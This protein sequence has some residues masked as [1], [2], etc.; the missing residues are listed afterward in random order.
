MPFA[1]VS[2]RGPEFR[3]PS[4]KKQFNVSLCH[5]WKI[6]PKHSDLRRGWRVRTL[7]IIF[8]LMALFPTLLDQAQAASDAVWDQHPWYDAGIVCLLLVQGLSIIALVFQRRVR[9][10][11]EAELREANESLEK[12]VADRTAAL[13]ES[14]RRLRMALDAAYMISFE[15]DIERNTV[16]RNMSISPALPA[17][18]ERT[19]DTL[20]AVC[21]VV[22]PEDQ[23]HFI[24]RVKAAVDGEDAHYESEFRIVYPDGSVRWLHEHGLVERDT[25]GKA[26]R[27]IGLSQDI[28]ERKNMEIALRESRA[29][30]ESAL[31]SMTDAVFI[32]DINGCFIEINDAF[33]AY[34]RFKDK[35]ACSKSFSDNVKIL[36]ALTEDGQPVPFDQWAVP[37]ALRGERVSGAEYIMRRKDTGE[38]WVGSYSFGP[39]QEKDGRIAGAVIVARDVTEK[40]KAEQALKESEA[41]YRDL[42]ENANSAIIGWRC[43]GSIEYFNEFA[44]KLFGYTVDEVVGR[45]A[46]IL[47]PGKET[48]GSDLTGLVWDIVEY[49]DQYVNHINENIRR[50]GERI[51]MSWTNRPVFDEKGKVQGIL[52]IGNDITQQKMAESA[53][54]WLSQFP[55]E[56]PSP[57]LRISEKGD[58]LYRNKA[59]WKWLESIE[60]TPDAP[61][62]ASICAAVDEANEKNRP[63][64][65]EITGTSG[66][67]YGCVAVRPYGESYINLYC[68]DLTERKKVQAALE[69]SE[70]RLKASLTEKEVLLKEIHHR[71]KNNMQV[72]SSLV[73]LQADESGDPAVQSVL[74]DVKHRVRSMAM[75]HEK[76]Y[77]SADLARVEFSDYAR[78][79]L[80]YIQSSQMAPDFAIHLNID[81]EPLFLPIN[82]AVP[83]GLI[84]NE[85]FSN[86]LKHAFIGRKN[87]E[88]AVS[89]SKKD[90]GAV[91][92]YVKDNGIGLPRTIE[93]DRAE[94]LGLRLIKMLARQL[95]ATVEILRENGTGFIITF[96][97]PKP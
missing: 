70:A 41:R 43:D 93:W 33:A 76:L 64:E 27:L 34:H 44:L 95:R 24:A 68:M 96:E 75:V 49:P 31:A 78:S 12:H 80:E 21:K 62:P 57:V 10:H 85:L 73:D 69:D 5:F 7:R 45:H 26:L 90:H 94:S 42:V 56:N 92:L 20:E 32:S 67:T 54:R 25:Q 4:L 50:N 81:M 89:L 79:L 88:V 38:T 8:L 84:L 2:S 29:M 82:T 22:H 86:A 83:A 35:E 65:V 46:S 30:L 19:P 17:T 51:W 63:I 91:Q 37:R 55:E 71:V 48:T 1:Q 87:G 59:A 61:L 14:E 40:R 23:A 3:S 11:A 97:V 53:L 36:E 16:R 39:I 66:T 77:Q 28:T 13:L 74:Q 47:L 72:I 18:Q 58:L 9:K 15:W 52:A 60:W 6:N